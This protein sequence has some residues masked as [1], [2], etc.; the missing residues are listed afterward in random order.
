MKSFFPLLVVLAALFARGAALS[1][2]PIHDAAVMGDLEAVKRLVKADPSLLNAVDDRGRT[3]LHRACFG[4]S[5]EVVRYLLDQGAPVGQRDTSYQLSPLHFAAWNGH[6]EVAKLL[7]SRGADLNARERDNETALFYA[8]AEGHAPMAEYLLSRGA[9][10]NDTLSRVGNTVV[11]L[12]LDRRKPE[13]VRLLIE[14]GASVRMHPRG[15][16]PAN[17][18]LM[19]TAAWEGGKE[20]IEFL[21]S[22]GVPIDRKTTGGRTPLHNACMQGNI[23]GAKALAALGADVN[24]IMDDGAVPLFFAISR[25]NFPLAS[26]LIESGAISL[27]S[28]RANGM[29]LLHYAATKGYSDVAGLLVDKGANVKAK[30]GR[31]RTALDCAIQYGQAACA[32]LLKSRGSRISKSGEAGPKPPKRGQAV[33]YY[34]GHSGWAVRTSGHL[35]VFDY[36]KGDRPSDNPCLANGTICPEELKDLK[37][38]SFTSHVHGDHYMPAIFDW[39]KDLADITYVTGFAPQGKEGYIQLADRETRVVGGLEITTIWSNDTGQGFLV[40]VDGISILHPGDHAN[41]NRD[42]SGNYAPEIDFLAAKSG[43]VD[44]MFVPVTGCNFG[45]VVAVRTGAYYAIGKLRPKAVFPMHGGEGGQ[46]YREFA[47]L[48][49]KE[50]IK[51]PIYAAEFAGDKWVLKLD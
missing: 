35:L 1:A 18:T 33:V 36:F 20:F 48:A 4:G 43:T 24:A 3:P 9:D 15:E 13:M 2:V 39:R 41:R 16:Y 46:Q 17:W 47:E 19:H 21:A 29:T 49:R 7:L 8:A 10:L 34:L 32:A 12:A 6:V 45:D 37:V 28:N 5:A 27:E 31:G 25:G 30:D 11:S 14:K 23:E 26:F 44:I 40:K 51:T 38:I 42:L 22:H 50:G